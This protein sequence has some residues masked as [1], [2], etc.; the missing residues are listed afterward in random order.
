MDRESTTL[1]LQE[2]RC[3]LDKADQR[4]REEARERDHTEAGLAVVRSGQGKG[5]EINKGTEINKVCDQG[6]NGT[7]MPVALGTSAPPQRHVS[8]LTEQFWGSGSW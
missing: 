5:A 6:A 7:H 1:T 3:R 8:S 2:L 4:Q